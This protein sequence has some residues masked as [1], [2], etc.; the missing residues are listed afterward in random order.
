MATDIC[1]RVASVAFVEF[2]IAGRCMPT[3]LIAGNIRPLDGGGLPIK[4][5]GNTKYSST[6][7][8]PNPGEGLL[9]SIDGVSEARG[10]RDEDFSISRLMRTAV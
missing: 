9:L 3:L 7:I 8:E 5:L 1:G 2:A 4:L 6:T 10:P